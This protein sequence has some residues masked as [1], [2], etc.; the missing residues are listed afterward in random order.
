MPWKW[1]DSG[2]GAPC[3]CAGWL[4]RGDALVQRAE[5]GTADQL[6]RIPERDWKWGT[7]TARQRLVH[8]LGV[9]SRMAAAGGGLEGLGRLAV[10]VRLRML[11]RWPALRP[12]PPRRP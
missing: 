2:F 3:A 4:L 12:L 10:A 7:A 8:R 11:A 5:R 1:S 9:V 6:A